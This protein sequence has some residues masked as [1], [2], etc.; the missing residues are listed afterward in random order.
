MPKIKPMQ[1]D[2]LPIYELM[3]EVGCCR[4]GGRKSPYYPISW[5]GYNVAIELL[6]EIYDITFEYVA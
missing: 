4:S 5:L 3:P 6:S 2:Q 1:G